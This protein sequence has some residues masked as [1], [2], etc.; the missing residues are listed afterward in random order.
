MRDD[1]QRG[2]LFHRGQTVNEEDH[3]DATVLRVEKWDPNVGWI[4]ALLLRDGSEEYG[5]EGLMCATRGVAAF[6]ALAKWSRC[7]TEKD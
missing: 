7:P 5:R 4:Y 1:Y 6:D 2:P 3:G